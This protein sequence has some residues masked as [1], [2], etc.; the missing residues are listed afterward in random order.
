MVA[1]W[2]AGD[3]G[4]RQGYFRSPGHVDTVYLGAVTSNRRQVTMLGKGESGAH[5]NLKETV[6]TE[7]DDLEAKLHR[8]Q[9]VLTLQ[10]LARGHKH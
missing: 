10:L 8:S 7:A 3:S 4:L 5:L 1:T 9:P 2:K 6:S